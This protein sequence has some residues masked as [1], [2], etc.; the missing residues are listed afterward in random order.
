MHHDWFWKKTVEGM[1]YSLSVSLAG[2]RRLN[3]K[4]RCPIEM[5]LI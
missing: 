1:I 5:K 3:T 4:E 2:K